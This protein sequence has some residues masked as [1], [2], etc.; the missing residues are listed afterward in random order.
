MLTTRVIVIGAGIGGLSAAALLAKEGFDVTV[1]ERHDQ[2]GGRARVYSEK[3][4]TFDMGPSWYLMPDVFEA[5][6]REFGKVPDDYYRLLRLDPSYRV[7]FEGQGQVD[8]TP[9]LDRVKETFEGFEPGA[10]DKFQEYLDG[11]EYQYQVAM[12]EF[13]YKDYTR[14]TQFMNRKL[15]VQGSKLHLLENLDKYISRYFDDHRIRKILEYNIVFLGGAPKDS[16]ALYALMAHVDFNMGVW[17]PEGGLTSMVQGFERLAKEQGA[18]IY[19]GHDVKGIEVEDG[20]AKR[21]VTDKGTFEADVVIANADMHH[22]ETDLLEPRFRSYS[23]RY[24]DKRKIAPSTLLFYLGL[25]KRVENLEHHNLFLMR[26]WD[27][28]FHTLFKDPKW[29]DEASYYVSRPS[30][31]DPTV[32][33]EGTDAVF[34]L[35]PVAAGLEDTDEVREKY[36]DWVIDHLEGLTGESIRDHVVLKRSYAHRDFEEDYNAYKGTALG[37]AHTLRQTAVFRP[38]H[39]SKK[40]KNL[41]YSGHYNHPGIGVPMVVIS[42][43]IV[44]EEVVKDHAE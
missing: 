12:T 24:W 9:D 38:K 39:R 16:P 18:K 35:I 19:Y 32:A 29:P 40:V 27:K 7:F 13:V 23:D 41:Y 15:L 4:Y 22:V 2:P 8:M 28:H 36:Y 14:L 21:V 25:D 33:P 31:T 34:I 42:S 11:T 20:V 30:K 17:Y 1:L 44:S 3:G 37:L 6:Y 26:D 5:F 43:Q 10:A